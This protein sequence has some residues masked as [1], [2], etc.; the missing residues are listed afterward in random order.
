AFLEAVARLERTSRADHEVEEYTSSPA[1][2][3][4]SSRR[5]EPAHALPERFFWSGVLP[6]SLWSPALCHRRKRSTPGNCRA[7]RGRPALRGSLS[8]PVEGGASVPERLQ[9]PALFA[10]AGRNRLRSAPHSNR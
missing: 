9:W 2:Q 10:E 1:P 4:A 7:W 8:F 3:Q 6:P 5:A